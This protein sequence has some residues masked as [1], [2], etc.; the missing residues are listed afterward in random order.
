MP[1]ICLQIQWLTRINKQLEAAAEQVEG[2]RKAA[3]DAQEAFMRERALRRRL[4]E[5]LQV[6]KGNIRVMCRVRPVAGGGPGMRCIVSYPLE[7]L[8]A[9]APP[10]RRPQE[11]E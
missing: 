5:Q 3:A 2:L 4:H 6:V 11:F 9:V 8:L 7:G 10:D 1:S